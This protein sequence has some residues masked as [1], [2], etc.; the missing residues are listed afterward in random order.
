M[1]RKKVI[2]LINFH[3]Q[4]SSN[5]NVWAEK[6]RQLTH[7]GTMQNDIKGM[8]AFYTIKKQKNSQQ[9]IDA[10]DH[11]NEIVWKHRTI[12]TIQICVKSFFNSFKL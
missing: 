2:Q 6:Q 12:Q 8:K 3:K 4:R 1:F 7:F 9:N 11:T 10:T 5:Q